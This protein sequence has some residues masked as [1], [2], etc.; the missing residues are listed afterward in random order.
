M[1]LANIATAQR[2]PQAALERQGARLIGVDL[3]RAVAVVHVIT[4]HLAQYYLQPSNA[5]RSALMA[6][7][8]DGVTLFFVISGFVI[9]RT[10]MH[11]E[12]DVHQMSLRAFY[13]ARIARIQPLL[14]ASILLGAAMLSLGIDTAPFGSPDHAPFNF[15]F[16]LSLLTFSFNWLHLAVSQYGFSGWGLHWDVMWTLAIEEQ[17]YL[18][19]PLLFVGQKPK[20]FVP[21]LIAIIIVCN[22]LRDAG[23]SYVVAWDFTSFAGFDALGLGV[24]TAYLAHRSDPRLSLWLMTAGLFAIAVGAT[25]HD[26][27]SLLIAYGAAA[28]VLGAQARDDYF[29][30]A[31]L[32][33]RLGQLSY[34]MYLIHPLVIAVLLPTFQA[35]AMRFDLALLLS[36]VSTALVA[37]IVETTFT[38]PTNIWLRKALART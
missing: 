20:R 12:A 24:L 33:A 6:H 30:C 28:F 3:L 29:A 14:I 13:I 17:F 11:R 38:R 2:S 26:A 9:T 15:L 8:S 18:L 23:Q 5:L 19:L 1:N 25:A 37:A 7:S 34:E 21:T 10:I 22:F 36:V 32:P 27:R 35:T 4:V 31:R 16:W